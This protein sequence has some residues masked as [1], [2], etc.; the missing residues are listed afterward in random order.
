LVRGSPVQAPTLGK[1]SQ[2]Y[3]RPEGAGQ[4][5]SEMIFT[6]GQT[7]LQAGLS[8]AAAL[9]LVFD[10]ASLLRCKS[11]LPRLQPRQLPGSLMHNQIKSVPRTL[12][13]M[14]GGQWVFEEVNQSVLIFQVGISS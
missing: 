5:E 8:H 6:F 7:S 12:R 13:G 1:R 4:F 3:F 14:A 9:R 10:T 2:N 11:V